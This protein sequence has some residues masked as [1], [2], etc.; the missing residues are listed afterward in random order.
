MYMYMC[1][2]STDHVGNFA[3]DAH[4]PVLKEPRRAHIRKQY[5][6]YSH[7]KPRPAEEN[8]F[9]NYRMATVKVFTPNS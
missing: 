1:I 9:G 3:M 6:K 2:A 4:V 5:T 8:N 7:Q